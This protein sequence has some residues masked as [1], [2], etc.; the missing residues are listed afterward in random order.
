[1]HRNKKIHG[2]NKQVSTTRRHENTQPIEDKTKK[3]EENIR[4]E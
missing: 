2:L 4:N 3:D 1:M